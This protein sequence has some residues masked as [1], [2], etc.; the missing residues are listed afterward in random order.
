M[1]KRWFA[2]MALG[3]LAGAAPLHAGT[4]GRN[5]AVARTAPP[6]RA[7]AAEATGA[8]AIRL[9]GDFGEAVWSRAVPITEFLQRDPKEGA[10]PS[11]ATEAR[12]AYDTSYLYV[13]VRAFDSDAGKIVGIRTRRDSSSPSDWIRVII[14]S[15]HDRR[16]AYEFAVNAA[17]VKQDRY[18]FADGNQRPELGRRVGRGRLARRGGVEG[19]VP[20]SRSRSCG[21]SRASATRSA[22]RVIARDRPAE[23]NLVVAAASR[24]AAPGSCRSS[25]NWA[26]CNWPAAEAPRGGAVRRGAGVD[27]ADRGGEPVRQVAGPGRLRRR[28][29]QVRADAGP[30]ADGHDQPGL[31]PGRGRPGRRQPDGVRDV[32]SRSGGRSSS[33]APATS[34]STSTA[35]TARAR[36]SST[37]GASAVSRTGRRTFRPAASR[38]C[39]SR[40]PSSARP[41]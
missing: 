20:H 31:R 27:A 17:G 14:D 1:T 4:D 12:V 22:S 32:L 41:S 34:S 2:A 5:G 30:D 10:P 8:I 7:E 35:T 11:F 24:R 3:L 16:T 23:R 19:R 33:R 6:P 28:R 36:A 26:A 38:R 18:W 25:A 37:R 40:R 39:P 9:D 13:A 29:H 21:S 15:Y